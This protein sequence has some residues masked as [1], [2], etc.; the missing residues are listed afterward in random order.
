MNI[1]P[2]KYGIQIW[3]DT[4]RTFSQ[5]NIGWHWGFSWESFVIDE[6][7]HVK[8]LHLG[9]FIFGHQYT[10]KDAIE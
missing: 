4:Y 5:V 6:L 1:T 7:N 8:S 2:Y 10:P 3:R 9:P